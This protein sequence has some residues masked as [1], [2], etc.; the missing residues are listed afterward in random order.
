MSAVQNDEPS[1]VSTTDAAGPAASPQP[2]AATWIALPRGAWGW[3]AAPFHTILFAAFPVIFLFAENAADQLVIAPLWEPLGMAI[4]GASVVLLVSVAITRS[5]VRGGL[6]ASLLV[7]LFFSFGHTWLL[8]ADALPSRWILVAAYAIVAVAAIPVIWRGGPWTLAVSRYANVAA[9]LLLSVNGVRVAAFV[10][11]PTIPTERDP[12]VPV[13]ETD[14]GVRRP[15]VYFFVFDRYANSETLERIYGYDN[16]PFLRSLQERG[17]AVAEDSWASYVKTAPS[18]LSTLSMEYLD[19]EALR[20]EGERET[21][22]PVHRRL[23]GSLAAPATLKSL[24]YEYVHIGSWWNPT[25]TNVDADVVPTYEGG[26]EF[27]SSLLNTTAWSLLE[28]TEPVDADT[29]TLDRPERV[30]RITLFELDRVSEAMRRPGPTYVFAHLL[31]PHPPYVFRADG[32][33]TSQPERN[34]TSR[35]ELYVEQLKYTNDRILELV[36]QALDVSPGEEPVIIVQ[37]DEGPHPPRFLDDPATFDWL[38]EATPEEILEKYGILNAIYLP[39][40]DAADA[41]V[42]DGMSPVNTFRIVF[43]EYFDAGLPL[44]PDRVYLTPDFARMYDFTEYERP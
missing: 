34:N 23:Q 16:G 41:G 19:G 1:R 29:E 36:D 32:S 22:A 40:V 6:I 9:I 31:I 13:G 15:D 24:G 43:N 21:F 44:L 14:D 10:S 35:E 25:S 2:D 7:L 3:T 11:T 28:P 38:A 26:T 33:M 30:R 17:F 37:A 20:A 18:L 27:G 42:H 5:L 8:V 4:A 12:A 39:G